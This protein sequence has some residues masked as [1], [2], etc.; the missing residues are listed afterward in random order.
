MHTVT[1]EDKKTTLHFNNDLSGQAQLSGAILCAFTGEWVKFD[2]NV[3]GV[4][5]DRYVK[6]AVDEARATAFT[7]AARA[8]CDH[9]RVGIPVDADGFHIVAVADG[10]KWG[11][12][13]PCKAVEIYALA[14]KPAGAEQDND[15]NSDAFPR[16]SANRPMA[17]EYYEAVVG[18]SSELAEAH[19]A[20]RLAQEQCEW[21]PIETAPKDGTDFLA[22]IPFNRKHHQIVGC[23]T[24]NGRFVSWPGRWNYEPSHWQPLPPTRDA[25]AE[26]LGEEKK[27]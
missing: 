21:Q 7:S 8:I 13:E 20:L 24:P 19:A 1:S 2:A 5:V 26:A 3:L 27:R 17:E 10:A 15:V 12:A 6:D 18:T 23:L 14:G 9:C 16:L 11:S 4:L 25:V 22:L